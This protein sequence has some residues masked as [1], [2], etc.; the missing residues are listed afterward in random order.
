MRLLRALSLDVVAG[1]ACGGLLAE[2]MT[3]ARMF[4]GLGGFL[5]AVLLRKRTPRESPV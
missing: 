5:R 1:A 3:R 2:H 4:P